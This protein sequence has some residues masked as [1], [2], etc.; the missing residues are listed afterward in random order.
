MGNSIETKQIMSLNSDQMR[1]HSMQMENKWTDRIFNH[2]TIVVIVIKL[3]LLDY[4]IAF[5]HVWKIG[6]KSNNK[7][8]D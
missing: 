1:I 4:I 8:N 6:K 3:E 2:T 5:V 7:I